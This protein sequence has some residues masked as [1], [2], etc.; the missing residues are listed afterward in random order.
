MSPTPCINATAMLRLTAALVLTITGVLA[1]DAQGAAMTA[2]DP[3]AP[4]FEL[5]EQD[6]PAFHLNELFRAQEDLRDPAF[7]ELRARYQLDAVVADATDEFDRILRLRHWIKQQ[8]AIED[9][10]PTPLPRYDAFTILDSARD[11]GAFH[12]AHFSIVQDAVLNAYGHV[13]RRLGAGDG[14]LERGRHHGVNEVWVND[15]AKW[16]LIDAKYD[17][18]FERDGIP[19]SALEMQQ[20]VL[21]DGGESVQRVYGPGREALTKEFPESMATYRWVCWELNTNRFSDRTSSVSSALA[22]VD[23]QRFRDEVWYRDG[24]P[25]W[26]YDARF[27]VP[28]RRDWIEWTPNVIAARV[29]ID[30]ATARVRIRS[31]TPNLRSYQLREGTGEWRDCGDVVELAIPADG[32]DLALRTINLAAVAGPPHRIQIRPTP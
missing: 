32:I 28:V 9:D 25:H 14:L 4:A 13:T 7:A 5:V 15:L 30:G 21:A 23:D 11:G 3:T 19:L 1:A 24:K 2:T 6:N 31:C 22:I 8:I 18:H 16:V 12:C 26:A 10:H 20:A 27:F 29:S 17:L